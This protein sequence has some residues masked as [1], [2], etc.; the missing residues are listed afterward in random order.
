[1]ALRRLILQADLLLFRKQ[2]PTV[3]DLISGL[4]SMN[5]TLSSITWAND[6]TD[7]CLKQRYVK[8]IQ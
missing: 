1:M 8:D 6:Y 5:A 3:S 2:L 4:E 7:A